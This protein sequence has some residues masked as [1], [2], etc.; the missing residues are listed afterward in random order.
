MAINPP[1]LIFV[2]SLVTTSSPGVSAE[3]ILLRIF[4]PTVMDLTLVDLPGLTKA[5]DQT[6]KP[7]SLE[8][9]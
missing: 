4:S 8:K 9:S 5:G 3:P 6:G 1:V 7:G 2:I